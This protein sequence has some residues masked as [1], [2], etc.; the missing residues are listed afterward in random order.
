[1]K[2]RGLLLTLFLLSFAAAL[3]ATTNIALN[4]AVTTN[5]TFL[6]GPQNIVCPGTPAAASTVDNG[7]FYAEQTCWLDGVAWQGTDLTTDTPSIDISFGGAFTISSAIVQA[8]D[9]DT[10]ELQYLGTDN[11]YHDWW[12]IPLDPSFGLVTRPSGN[13]VTQ[14]PLPTVVATGVRIFATS[15]DGDYSVGQVEVFGSPVGTPEPGSLMLL[16]G[17]LPG[18]ALLRRRK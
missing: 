14:Q 1:M 16:F 8:D 7:S 9:N 11:A 2:A 18:L 4:K 5:G 12:A 13:Q 17:A 3:S 6:S 10:Y 15:G